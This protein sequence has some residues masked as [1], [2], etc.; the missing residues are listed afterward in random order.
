MIADRPSKERD[1]WPPPVPTPVCPGASPPSPSPPRWPSTPRPRPSRRRASRSSASVP[2]SP[3]SPRRRRIVE[4]AVEACRDPRN[5][6]Y[7]PAGG[8]PEL[9]EAIA[10]KTRRDS[11]STSRRAR[12]SSPT[13]ASTPSTT[14]SPRSS[15]R[16]TRCS[17][18][19]PTGPPTPSRSRWPA[20]CSVVLPTDETTG[21]R[22][23]VEQLDAAVTDRTKALLFVSPSNPTGAVYPPAEVEAIGRWA[24]E[25]GHLGDHRRDLRAPH[26][27]RAPLQLDAHPR[28]RAARPLRRAQRR[29][30]DLRHDGLARRVDDR[31]RRHRQGG[32]EPAVA[33]HVQ[34]RQRQPAGRAR[35]G[36][37]RPQRGRRDAGGLRAAGPH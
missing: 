24:V 34:R 2:A 26:L 5:H 35:R 32:H 30:Q 18:R 28:A 10:V 37:G 12:C 15:T 21:F 1:R 3:T 23:T 9:K 17:C 16:A 6:K 14:P 29:G 13:A 36:V 33:R 25:R 11:G 8:L 20:A 19:R 22:V 31:A 4:A 7:T 27:R